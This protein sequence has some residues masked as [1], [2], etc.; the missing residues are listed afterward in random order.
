[1]GRLLRCSSVTYRSRYAPSSR[2]VDDPFLNATKLKGL[3]D[4]T[5]ALSF[6][7]AGFGAAVVSE[8]LQKI[9]PGRHFLHLALEEGVVSCSR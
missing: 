7:A 5:L 8:P 9:P 4:S 6:V 3:G 1:M 2:L